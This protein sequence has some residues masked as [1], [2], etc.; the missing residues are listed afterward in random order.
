MLRKS[1]CS[2]A[3]APQQAEAISQ[4]Q[5]GPKRLSNPKGATAQAVNEQPMMRNICE[6]RQAIN[7]VERQKQKVKGKCLTEK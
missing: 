3:R 1:V 7:G 5:R 2:L 6:M 4:N